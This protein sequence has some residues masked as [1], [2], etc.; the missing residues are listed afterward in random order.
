MCP[1]FCNYYNPRCCIQ[2]LLVPSFWWHSSCLSSCGVFKGN[3]ERHGE[4]NLKL[5]VNF[6]P[7]YILNLECRRNRLWRAYTAINTPDVPPLAN[8][9]DVVIPNV[10]QACASNSIPNPND[11]SNQIP[12]GA[13]RSGT[14]VGFRNVVIRRDGRVHGHCVSK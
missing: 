10:D 7:L 4:L 5:S 6:L 8:P 14:V 3:F 11:E 9:T 13:L 12:S 2:W 1:T